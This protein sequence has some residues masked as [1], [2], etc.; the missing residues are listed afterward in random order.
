[1]IKP[2]AIILSTRKDNAK[3]ILLNRLGRKITSKVVDCQV[4]N[5]GDLASHYYRRLYNCKRRIFNEKGNR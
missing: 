4:P 1:V 3:V 5:K 2:H